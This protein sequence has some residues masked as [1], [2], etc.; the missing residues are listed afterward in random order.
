MELEPGLTNYIKGIKYLKRDNPEYVAYYDFILNNSKEK[1]RGPLTEEA[2]KELQ[3][4]GKYPIKECYRNAQ[5]LSI[6]NKDIKY[7]EGWV[8]PTDIPI[9]IEH[10]W[11][12][13]KGKI[14]DVTLKQ[15][16]ATDFSIWDVSELRKELAERTHEDATYLG[17][18][19]PTIYVAKS[20]LKLKMHTTLLPHFFFNCIV[21]KKRNELVPEECGDMKNYKF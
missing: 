13:Y 5:T 20:V 15:R 2:E 4:L 19:I 18:E 3:N 17:V 8:E 10:A 1:K 14:I 6:C 12:E 11:N 21:P 16:N 7:I 9:P